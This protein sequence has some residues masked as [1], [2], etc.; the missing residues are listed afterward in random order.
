MTLTADNRKTLV[1]GWLDIAHNN[2][3][4]FVAVGLL[5]EHREEDW[6]RLININLKGIWLC[7]KYEIARMLE[8]GGGA[9]VN[10]ASAAGLVGSRGAVAYIASKHGV[11]GLTRAAA[12]EYAPHG[13]RVNA[14]CPGFVQTPMLEYLTGGDAEREAA[15][16]ARE[17]IG[18]LA[19]PEEIAAGVVWL[20]SDAASYVTGHA[21]AIDG[22]YVAQ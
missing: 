9:I 15:L 5:H 1:Y 6:D 22:G 3:G 13:I 17:P 4:V 12:L 2:A 19:R 7:M 20:C 14:V 11:V 8:Q 16:S 21:M 10:T 18:R